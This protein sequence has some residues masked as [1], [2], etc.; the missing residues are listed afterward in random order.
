MGCGPGEDGPDDVSSGFEARLRSASVPVTARN[1]QSFKFGH[2]SVTVV[3]LLVSMVT[4]G[5][6]SPCAISHASRA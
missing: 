1:G 3:I 6:R 5:G 4:K 2:S